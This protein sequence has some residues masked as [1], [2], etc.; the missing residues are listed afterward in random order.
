MGDSPHRLSG[1]DG[2][3]TDDGDATER[4]SSFALRATEDKYDRGDQAAGVRGKD[5]EGI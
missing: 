4:R 5:I 1:N 3:E 2:V